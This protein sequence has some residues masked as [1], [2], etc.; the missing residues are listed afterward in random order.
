M[1]NIYYNI[2]GEWDIICLWVFAMNWHSFHIMKLNFQSNKHF[3]KSTSRYMYTLSGFCYF[4]SNKGSLLVYR[5]FPWLYH[6][7]YC[8]VIIVGWWHSLKNWSTTR[9]WNIQR[10]SVTL[11]WDSMIGD[12]TMKHNFFYDAQIAFRASGSL[13]GFNP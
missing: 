13:L 11:L 5:L 10:E 4:Y 8:Y 3:R 7:R 2:F 12:E 9:K 6:L 1:S